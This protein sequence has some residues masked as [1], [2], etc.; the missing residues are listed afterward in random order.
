MEYRFLQK[1]NFPQLYSAFIEAFSDYV[2]KM[3]PSEEQFFEMLT[4]RGVRYDL[5]VGAFSGHRLVGFNLNA[6]DLWKGRLTVYDTGTG[7]IPEYRGQAIASEIFAFSFP[8]LKQ[9]S[10]QQYILEVIDS[11]LSA[12]KLYKKVGFRE[13]RKLE[14][15]RLSDSVRRSLSEESTGIEL[16]IA[17]EPDWDLFQSFW[18]WEPS[19]QNSINSIKRSLDNKVLVCAFS[20]GSCVGYGIIYPSN[21]DIPQLAVNK[22]YRRRRIGTQ[23]LQSLEMQ[24]RNGQ[25]GRMVNID[26]SAEGT[27]GFCKAVGMQKIVNQYEMLLE[28]S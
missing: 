28:L 19:W 18:D 27:L 3:Q 21:G 16:R 10:A 26:A 5:S 24:I 4:R 7:V 20:E 9:V 2:V 25:S 17:P 15:F 22:G 14:S 8:K 13:V 11:N 23:I 1:E 6:L 12:I